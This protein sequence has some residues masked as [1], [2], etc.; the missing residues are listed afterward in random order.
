MR[1]REGEKHPC[2]AASCTAPA[3]DLDHSPGL[4]ADWESNQEPFGSQAS[5]QSTEPHQSGPFSN[6]HL[7]SNYTTKSTAVM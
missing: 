2:V 7:I 6:I 1:G 5:A 3:G 4:C